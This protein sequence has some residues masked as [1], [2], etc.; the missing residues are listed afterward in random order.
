MERTNVFLGDAER[1][2]IATL[3]DRY[4]LASVGAAIR[5]ALRLA[6]SSNETVLPATPAPKRRR[7]AGGGPDAT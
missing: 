4:G 2:L 6:V 5:L 7:P 1:A 3:R